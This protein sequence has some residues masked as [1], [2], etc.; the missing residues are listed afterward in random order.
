MATTMANM[1]VIVPAAVIVMAMATAVTATAEAAALA[2]ASPVGQ[3]E[4]LHL[5]MP[6]NHS[7]G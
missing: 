3:Y 5:T 6:T 2:L 4:Q 7:G 1:T